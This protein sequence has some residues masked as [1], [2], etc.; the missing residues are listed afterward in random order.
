MD[1]RRWIRG[2]GAALVAC[3]LITGCGGDDGAT[4]RN[5][6][7]EEASASDGSA[8]SAGSGSTAETD[9]GASSS[10]SSSAPAE[11]STESEAAAGEAVDAEGGYTYASDVTAHRQVT[12]DVCGIKEHLDADTPNFEA[13]AELYSDGEYS[14]NDDGSVR[15]LAGFAT[16]DDRLHGLDDYYGTATP[17]DDWMTEALGAT[18]RFAG[19]SDDVRAQAVEKGAQNQILVAWAI[20]ELNSALEKVGAGDIDPAEGAPHNWD[21]AWAFYHGAAPD[22][23]P[24][25][26]ANS[27]AENFGTVSDDGV[28]QANAAITEAMNDGRDALIAGDA[29]AASDAA[30]EVIRNLVITYSQAAIRYATLVGQ[31]VENDDLDAAAEHR[32]EGLAFFG[33]VEALVA[34]RGADV[35]AVNAVFDLD[36]EPGSNGGPD[37]IRVALQ[38]A[39][40]A[41]GISDDDIGTL[42]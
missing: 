19:A 17:L 6:A 12:L 37:E 13:A 16:A 7:D 8:S 5:L 30:D 38:P 26:T 4:V 27:R 39:W 1:N 40:E 41:L 22:C 9:G 36:A 18:G 32:V 3:L 10:A 42:Q 15:T 35:E 21:E 14:I 24:F 25:A 34:D 11:G 33:V 23:A 31:D 20:H 2:L 29:R 28:A